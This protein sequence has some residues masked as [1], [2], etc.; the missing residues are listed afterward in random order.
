M[1]IER[2][3]LTASEIRYIAN[4]I[5]E[6]D[7]YMTK[8]YIKY[9]TVADCCTDYKL[10][11]EKSEDNKED[12]VVWKEDNY[13]KFWEEGNIEVLDREIKNIY[14]IDKAV[15]DRQSTYNMFKELTEKLS[16]SIKD[17]DMD[18]TKTV[19]NQ[20]GSLINKEEK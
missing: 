11:V 16:E 15:E 8:Q 17:F 7:D 9:L 4:M 13:N 2:N 14:L 6:I 19:I 20:I 12:S 5:A 18:E 1:K 3:Y 10:E